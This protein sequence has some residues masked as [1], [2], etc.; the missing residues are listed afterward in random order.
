MLL[1]CSGQHKLKPLFLQV[2]K[3]IAQNWSWLI[4][5]ILGTQADC[6]IWHAHQDFK[7]VFSLE[8]SKHYKKLIFVLRLFFIIS[9]SICKRNEP[10]WIIRMWISNYWIV[11]RREDYSFLL[12]PDVLIIWITMCFLKIDRDVAAETNQQ[13]F[14]ANENDVNHKTF[15]HVFIPV[16]T[17]LLCVPEVTADPDNCLQFNLFLLKYTAFCF[18]SVCLFFYMNI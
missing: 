4:A 17:F 5:H 12:V 2:G 11:A 16:L 14:A 8:K 10:F 7:K 15:L 9:Y 13:D 18:L 3:W 1:G 6:L